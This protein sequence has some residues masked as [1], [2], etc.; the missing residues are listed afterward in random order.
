MFHWIRMKNKELEIMNEY[1]MLNELAEKEGTVIF[2]EGED[3]N[4]PLC[5]LKQA[6]A[7]NE[8]LYNRS[9][10]NICI[11]N[12]AEIYETYVAPLCPKNVFVHLGRNDIDFFSSSSDEFTAAYTELISKIKSYN[13]NCKIAVVSLKNYDCD[14]KI[15]KLNRQLKYIAD[16]EKCEFCDISEKKLRA[17][18]QTKEIVSFMY[19]IGFVRRIKNARPLRDLAQMLFCC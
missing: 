8:T 9:F 10:E 6:F 16:S 14:P 11:K 5:E 2:G 17:F 4:L 3:I 12:A 7:L 1:K 15:G 19:D 18:K 13:K